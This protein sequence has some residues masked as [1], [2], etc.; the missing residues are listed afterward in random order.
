V[1]KDLKKRNKK[2]R[3]REVRHDGEL[4]SASVVLTP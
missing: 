4:S 1:K 2:K 3:E